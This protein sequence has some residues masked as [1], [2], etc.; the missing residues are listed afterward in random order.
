MI[1]YKLNNTN[2]ISWW[3]IEQDGSNYHITWGQDLSTINEPSS[4]HNV[5]QCSDPERAESEI[6]SK[7]T[8]QIQRHGY[9]EHKPKKQPDLPML[10]QQ[11]DSHLKREPFKSVSIQPKLD[12]VRCIA[13]NSTVTTRKLLDLPTIPI[14]KELLANLSP[15]DKLDGELY[16]HGCDLQLLQGMVVR[17]RPHNAHFTIEYHVFDYV[18]LELPFI[19]RYNKASSIVEY[20]T[21]IYNAHMSTIKDIPEKLRPK[22]RY[23]LDC[24]IKLVPNYKV[25]NHSH[26]EQV[27]HLLGQHFRSFTKQ[28]YEGCIVRDNDG[29]YELD[30]RSPALLKYKE[31]LDEEFECIDVSEGYNQT[32]IFV[33]K[34]EEGRIFEATPSWTLDRK[35]HL[36]KNKEKFVGRLITVEFEKY[37]LDGIPLKPVGKATRDVT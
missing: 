25:D 19:E 28:G 33:C 37:S 27:K 1:L 15:E 20:L 4:N 18:D 16:I 21:E 22:K 12:G 5:Y 11:W 24:P 17:K 31:R 26:S 9:T 13:T 36:L 34:T 8:E 14:I 3:K 29:L 6:E 32:G 35:R 7:I 30:Y 23:P 2:R 10:A